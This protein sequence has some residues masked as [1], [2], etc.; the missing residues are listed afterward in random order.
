MQKSDTKLS[1]IW[2]H[3]ES[4]FVKRSCEIGRIMIT[5]CF[6]GGHFRTLIF[7]YTRLWWL[8][9][10]RTSS[11]TLYRALQRELNVLT[12]ILE[13]AWILTGPTV[14]PNWA[15]SHSC[16][17][18]N[19]LTKKT[20]AIMQSI[21]SL[22]CHFT[23]SYHRHTEETCELYLTFQLRLIAP[24]LVCQNTDKLSRPTPSNSVAFNRAACS[25]LKAAAVCV[26][27]GLT[28]MSLWRSLFIF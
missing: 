3:L 1:S 20:I 15:L 17:T 22:T 7:C 13:S 11:C 9:I 4:K 26:Y 10:K 16:G 25:G 23:H 12:A 6:L 28:Q 21:F 14:Q 18:P 5:D 8:T 24:V 2:S 19:T 27:H